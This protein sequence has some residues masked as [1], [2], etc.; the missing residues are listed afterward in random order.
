[1]EKVY[2]S[3]GKSDRDII[4]S[5]N[6]IVSELGIEE[7]LNIS[8]TIG[9]SNNT[10]NNLIPMNAEID[11]SN[12]Y[13]DIF[14]VRFDLTTNNIELRVIREDTLL[15]ISIMISGERN[16]NNNPT[17]PTPN[18]VIDVLGVVQ[19]NFLPFERDEAYDKLLGDE[20]AEFYRKREEGLLKLE[21]LSQRLIENNQAYRNKVDEEYSNNN[22]KIK[23][24]YDIKENKLKDELEEERK[25]LKD[26]EE[27]LNK[28]L[29]EFD[30]RSS[31]HVRREI[32]QDL[33]REIDDRNRKFSLTEDT[34]KKRKIIHIIFVFFILCLCSLIVYTIYEINSFKDEYTLY[35]NIRLVF[36][37]LG[38]AATTVY[39]IRWNDNWFKRHADEEFN[40]KRFQL[41]IDRAS[42]VVEMAMEWKDEKGSEI[43]KELI[44]RL[45]VNLFQSNTSTKITHPTEDVLNRVL[46]S[47]A[48][49][50]VDIPSLGSIKL[51]KK[52]VKE[53]KKALDE[54][55]DSE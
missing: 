12:S 24:E 47:S 10:V 22:I 51:N 50:N 8:V 20:L 11:N 5:L 25:L 3:F 38:F 1:M 9:S 28:K 6:S 53:L 7:N 35:Y 41:D 42:W 4:H 54:N 43:P 15:K 39:Y 16:R 29:K 40:I 37:V 17:Q 13:Y 30:D 31:K 2:I 45:T 48:E 33:K 27:E 34:I 23:E 19:G 26:K 55:E 14:V 21:S 32:R 36:S 49:L 46:N 52:G 18:T 44:D